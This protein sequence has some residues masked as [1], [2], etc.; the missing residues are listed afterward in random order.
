MNTGISRAGSGYDDARSGAP[1]ASITSSSS[2]AGNLRATPSGIRSGDQSNA[3]L[4][5]QVTPATARQITA[6]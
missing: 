2:A 4:A 6:T 3:A 1:P 5:S